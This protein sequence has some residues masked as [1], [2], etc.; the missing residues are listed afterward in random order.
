MWMRIALLIVIFAM[1]AVTPA[2]AQS[3]GIVAANPLA[4]DV[5]RLTREILPQV[6]AWRRDFHQHP[7][8]GNSERRTAKVIADTLTKLGY[9]V[10]TGVAHTGVVAVLK[11]AKPGPVVALRADM[12]ALPVTEQVDLPFKSTAKAMWNGQEVGVMHACGH[13][14]HMAILLGAATDPAKAPQNHSPLF[15][16][17]ESALPVGV[18]ALANLALDYLFSAST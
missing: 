2:P 18:K 15:F 3:S 11:G 4:G 13:D 9:E 7:E 8:P 1:L 5:D 10:K 16:A 17:D 12:D 6:V 14:N